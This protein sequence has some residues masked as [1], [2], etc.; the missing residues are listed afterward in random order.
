MKDLGAAEWVLA[1]KLTRDRPKRS[2]TLTQESYIDKLL[3]Q[4]GLADAKPSDTPE[5]LTKLTRA[6]EATMEERSEMQ[7]RP[8]MELVGSLLYASITCH[9][10]ISHAVG[11]LTRSMANPGPAHWTAAKRV[12]R[13]LKSRKTRG[14]RFAPHTDAGAHTEQ[15]CDD[16]G[17][18]QTAAQKADRQN[19]E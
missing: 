18:Q 1:M 3:S 8:Y 17:T 4:F 2:I 12:L 7:Q 13:Y 19:H 11:I 5:E 14:L 9:P 16:E 10:S 15:G 6:D